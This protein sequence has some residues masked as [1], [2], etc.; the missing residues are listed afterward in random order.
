MVGRPCLA[1]RAG[2]ER[3]PERPRCPR[4]LT[5]VGFVRLLCPAV[6]ATPDIFAGLIWAAP[7]DVP[8]RHLG[9]DRLAAPGLS[10]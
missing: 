3:R 8:G 1:N 5:L 9:R 10:A 6:R 7:R 2:F 4:R